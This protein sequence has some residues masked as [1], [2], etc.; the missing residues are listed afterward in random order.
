LVTLTTAAKDLTDRINT[1][2]AKSLNV[3]N[4][5]LKAPTKAKRTKVN[6]FPS[7]APPS[8][9]KQLPTQ[10]AVTSTATSAK[11]IADIRSDFAA[12]QAATAAQSS[13]GTI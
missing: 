8:K 13:L 3:D 5:K 9:P 4:T 7:V 11:D 12:K 1:R 10:N 6:A 2:V